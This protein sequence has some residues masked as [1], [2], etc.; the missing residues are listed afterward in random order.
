MHSPT[1]LRFALALICAMA[2]L[3]ACAVD[4]E[5]PRTGERAPASPVVGPANA[6][7]D[8]A[9]RTAHLDRVSRASYC[10]T[11]HPEATAEHRMNTHG[12]AFTDEEVRLATAR[13]SIDGCIPCHTPRPVFETGIGM[14]PK[15]RLAHL[16]EGNDCFS[17]H[18]R[19]GF[20]FS[21]FVGGKA[22]CRAAFDERVSEVEACAS[23]H[24]N[25]GT[26]YQW[27]NAE[28]GKLAGN[29][30]VDCHMPKVVR[31]VAVGEPARRTRR[32][33]FFAS[34]SESQLR[35]AYGYDAR[36]DGNEVVVT[37]E[38]R[39]AGHNFPTELKQRAVESV[40]IV[41]D[42]D[43]NEVVNTR[44]VHRDPYKRPYG[45]MLPVN[46]QI[47]SGESR[48]HRVPIT[49]A[50]GTVE[51]ALYYKLYFPIEDEH[52]TLS[53][54]LETRILP[55]HDVTPSTQPVES[56]P[57]LD[58]RLPEALPAEAASPGNLVDFARPK[59]GKV[60]VEIPDGSQAGDV[61]K[62]IALF[63]FPVG[64]ANR[65]AQDV[66]VSLGAKAT[67]ELV[68][69]LGSWDGKTWTQAKNVLV[70][71][72]DAGRQAVVDALGH[73]E[74]YVKLHAQET[75]PRFGDLGPD[76]AVAVAHLERGLSSEDALVRAGSALGL[77]QLRAAD[78]AP[79]IRPLLDELDWDVCATAARALGMLGDARSLPL[80]RSTFERVKVSPE[81]ARDLAWA[82]AALG[83][84]SGIPFLMDGLD[85][86]DD[87]VRESF[88]EAYL[89]VTGT[90]R[91]YTPRLASEDR[92]T[93]LADLR[94]WWATKGG[95]QALRA[96][97]SI[98]IPTQ[99]RAEVEKLV[100]D[101]GGDDVHGTTPEQDER[102]VAR[103]QEIGAAATP[104]VVDGLKWPSGF[105]AKRTC[106]L[107]ALAASPDPDA[108][109]AL[110]DASRD[111]LPLVGLWAVEALGALADPSGLEAVAQF[112]QRIAGLAAAGRLP[113]DV[114]PLDVVRSIAARA[115]ARMGA[116][117][118]GETL[119][120]LLWSRHPGA[121]GSAERALSELYGEEHANE[122]PVA[123][124]ARRALADLPQ[125]RERELERL[126]REWEGLVTR[127]EE[128]GGAARSSAERLAAL[129]S[130]DLA[131]AAVAR[132]AAR[133]TR[134]WA[135]DFERTHLGAD[136]LSSLLA[137]DAA[138]LA[139]RRERNLLDP[140]ERT[141][142]D[143]SLRGNARARLD[144]NGLAFELEPGRTE[145]VL[146]S[147]AG[148][149]VFGANEAWRDYEI[150]LEVEL[151][152]GGLGLIDRCGPLGSGDLT[153]VLH[154]KGSAP[155]GI[156]AK[157]VL[158]SS[159]KRV[160]L[161]QRVYGS[162]VERRVE[163]APEE[164]ALSTPIRS[165]VRV[166]GLGL[167]I[168][169]GTRLRISK[170]SVRVLRVDTAN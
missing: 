107:R 9:A 69:A 80:L 104:M 62:L 34:R 122:P 152:S 42:A 39:G 46:T 150:E 14:N 96:P 118:G 13:F 98:S 125:D 111:P 21:T 156:E 115:R 91:S 65:K 51:T 68:R 136:E 54:R 114:G 45:L 116:P 20:D 12:R 59:I 7:V 31:P 121:R 101:V 103:L 151:E 169:A 77:G 164:V 74:L 82:L 170:L 123:V 53:R 124:F 29:T 95:T 76:R 3:S 22:E 112:E 88:F 19:K 146:W 110:I 168:P 134:A 131:E 4:P 160:L 167:R 28:H 100:K 23:C 83:D 90:S 85:H 153:T 129:G 137:R 43:G 15:K 41:R 159:G 70:R 6:P 37:I 138:W 78:K 135:Q 35:R 130:Y 18:A 162:Q 93:A 47:P 120:G 40:V 133:D 30:C 127:A 79:L 75:L 139:E 33:T 89:D 148:S 86:Q 17:C 119:L 147:S 126:R 157:R 64:E 56:A 72:G 140:A 71:M 128:Q 117:E 84:A 161:R 5:S 48:E 2:A 163:G 92:L 57:E 99:L 142:W 16:E 25:H 144:A 49:V 63:Q 155:E 149:I 94:N 73:G 66:L 55:F 27:E 1:L 165:D 141:G 11:C 102:L 108:L 52:P 106:L 87:L 97:R 61:A 143:F 132:Y 158:V 50:N 32:H 67:P 113:Q 36:I 105:M 58:A 38:N 44:V 26:P 145:A 24:K 8:L 154:V 109:A 10:A 60:E 81:T 166:G